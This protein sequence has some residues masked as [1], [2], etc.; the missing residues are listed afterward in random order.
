MVKSNQKQSVLSYSDFINAL[1]AGKD[2]GRQ[3]FFYGGEP[4]LIDQAVRT[5]T[6]ANLDEDSREF[7]IVRMDGEDIGW[8]DLETAL[9]SQQMFAAKK[10]IQLHRPGRL[11]PSAKKA[12]TSYFANPSENTCLALV[13]SQADWRKKPYKDWAE[14][15]IRVQCDSL[16]ENE[17]A[18]WITTTVANEGFRIEPDQ[19]HF[20]ETVSDGDMQIISGILEKV[21]FLVDE[22]ENI[23]E[24]ILETATGSSR[25]YSW[26]SLLSAIAK[27]DFQSLWPVLDFLQQ[28]IPSATYFT[29]ILSRTFQGALLAQQFHGDIPFDINLYKS[30]GY[31]GSSR[32]L[33]NNISRA[34]TR[35]EIEEA[36]SQIR[37]TDRDI[38]NTSKSP[39]PLVHHMM[40]KI[41]FSEKNRNPSRDS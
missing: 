24:E 1:A 13:E 35:Q 39:M 15:L 7:G 4:F 5:F 33:I 16:P 8:A 10:V 3:I 37:T 34:Y 11:P 25:R 21:F 38:K 32:T 31:F 2:I 14:L 20:L 36:L 12:L 27:R 23:T 6:D 40:A 41:I 22:G 29:Q 30:I 9:S 17:L 18:E 28:Q 26:D 19:I